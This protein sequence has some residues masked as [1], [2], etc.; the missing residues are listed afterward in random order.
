MWGTYGIPVSSCEDADAASRFGQP[1]FSAGDVNFSNPGTELI[2]E[3]LGKSLT[4][5]R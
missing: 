2:A 1:Q 3:K 5:L 4:Q